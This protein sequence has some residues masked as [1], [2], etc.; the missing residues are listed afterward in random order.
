MS[1]V[2]VYFYDKEFNSLG[3]I[4]DAIS[5]YW[6]EMFQDVGNFSIVVPLKKEYVNLCRFENFVYVM[7]GARINTDKVGIIEY[8]KKTNDGNKFIE[9]R[10]R[11]LE[12]IFYRR[13]IESE[14]AIGNS[15]NTGFDGYL[16]TLLYSA[17]HSMFVTRGTPWIM[18]RR[19]IPWIYCDY[20]SGEQWGP[21]QYGIKRRGRSLFKLVQDTCIALECGFRLTPTNL[22]LPH[23]PLHNSASNGYFLFELYK[24]TDRTESQNIVRPLIFS[25]ET[26]TIT[27][28]E[29]SLSGYTDP[30]F[31][32]VA[33]QGEGVNRVIREVVREGWQNIGPGDPEYFQNRTGLDCREIWVDAR[34]LQR[35]ENQTNAQ[36]LDSLDVRGMTKIHENAVQENFNA[37]ILLQQNLTYK[38][39]FDLGDKATYKDIELN[40]ERDSV[41]SGIESVW[42]EGGFEQRLLFGNQPQTIRNII[43]N[44][45]EGLTNG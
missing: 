32:F 38:V 17:V 40:V 5:I 31:A 26:N 33:G 19:R 37:E 8:I 25:S 18:N 30:E 24:G 1:N 39:D 29:Y 2:Q 20:T 12:S 13:A 11:F 22:D 45:T 3:V 41:I 14:G 16:T 7:D 10:G 21:Y 6:A 35:G 28:A 4:G 43:D 23:M 15:Q 44:S 9:V 34:D 36:Y 42:R 27:N